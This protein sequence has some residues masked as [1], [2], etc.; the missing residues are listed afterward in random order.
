MHDPLVVAF[1]VRRPWPRRVNRAGRTSA[2]R[3]WHWPPLVTVW[4]VEPGGYDSG[5]VCKHHR[6]YVDRERV[7][8]G[9]KLHV[10][11]WRLQVHPLQ[12]LR[13]WLLTRC[14]WCG[15]RHTR[16][17]PV[18]HSLSW[19]RQ[20]RRWW[21]GE[22]G[23]YHGDCAGVYLAHGACTCDDPLTDHAGHG[24]CALC[25]RRRSYGVSAETLARQRQL[26][27]LPAGA[28][29]PKDQL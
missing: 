9:W 8:I 6:R 3:R 10:W 24:R 20:R 16:R 22:P 15:G 19:D 1:V 29:R 11:H 21:R 14:A 7:R 18:N 12:H 28:R 23:L 13:R 2:G 17:D 26:A 4:H 27:A 5:E 25:G